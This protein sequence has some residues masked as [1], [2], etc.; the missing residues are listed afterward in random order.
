M[1]VLGIFREFLVGLK[2]RYF[3]RYCWIFRLCHV[4]SFPEIKRNP[5]R[6]NIPY[7]N[8]S[9]K[10]PG[11]G[12]PWGAEMDKAPKWSDSNGE[13]AA[14]LIRAPQSEH[15]DVSPPPPQHLPNR[16]LLPLYNFCLW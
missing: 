9:Q 4:K 16:M 10:P 12:A 11:N 15:K 8:T 13:S 2:P 14:C 7:S 1:V 6:C 5:I 3:C